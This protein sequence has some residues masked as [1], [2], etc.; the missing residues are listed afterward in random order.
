MTDTAPPR[1]TL[2]QRWYRLRTSPRFPFV[3]F[4]GLLVAGG[5]SQVYCYWW[6]VRI[7][8][9]VARH[10]G[11]VGRNFVFRPAWTRWIPDK[12]L[13]PLEPIVS[14]GLTPSTLL[15]VSDVTLLEGLWSLQ[16]LTVDG[17]VS[18]AAWQRVPQL[19][20]LTGVHL[21]ATVLID[22]DFE[23]LARLPRLLSLS[24]GQ[25]TIEASGLRH[26]AKHPTLSVLSVS[27]VKT[28][29]EPFDHELP[30]DKWP[31]AAGPT[32]FP[33]ELMRELATS[34]N[35]RRLCLRNCP[36]FGDEHL[37]ALTSALSDGGEPLPWLNALDLSETGITSRGLTLLGNLPM[38]QDLDLSATGVTDDGLA[39]LKKIATLRT[40]ILAHTSIGDGAV[41]TLTTMQNL[42]VL[43]VN[44]TNISEAGL[45]ELIALKNLRR[46]VL[47]RRLSDEML[48]QLRSH[49]PCYVEE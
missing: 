19:T 14:V 37:L 29:A 42:E 15:P 9:M 20:G 12:T 27:N 11:G 46:L 18:S 26:F 22:G 1:L 48:L 33:V 25:S 40:L 6:G 2:R 8:W 31:Q 45:L 7:Q 13:D 36:G 30:R 39:A 17:P 34:Q 21:E 4:F 32:T 3:L 44:A 47:N 16:G 28:W 38:L 5:L 10:G 49:L 24:I 43:N 23:C 41:E 35:L